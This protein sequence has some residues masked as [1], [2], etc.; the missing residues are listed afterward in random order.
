VLDV[1]YT[2]DNKVRSKR[3]GK[4]KAFIACLAKTKL[5]RVITETLA[6]GRIMMRVEFVNG[7]HYEA[8]FTNYKFYSE[9]KEKMGIK[10]E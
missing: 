10:C 9:F 7:D 5:E 2:S 8:D 1:V 4:Y 6:Q 3:D